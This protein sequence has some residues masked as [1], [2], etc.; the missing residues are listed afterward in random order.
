MKPNKF[1]NNK[2]IGIP[3]ALYQL[4]PAMYFNMLD[5]LSTKLQKLNMLEVGDNVVIQ[6]KTIIRNPNNIDLGD[7]VY[8]AREVE[9]TTE[10]NTSKLS[11][12]SGTRIAKK[13]YI[14]YTGNIEIGRSCTLSEN[15]MIQTHSHGLSPKNYAI[16]LSLKI[17]NNVWVGTRSVILHNVSVIGKNS[18][19]AAG[20]VVTKDVPENV[21]VAGNP[22]KVIKELN[23]K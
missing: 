17:N 3:G 10:I 13:T 5:K 11:I 22:A 16:P 2:I 9:M 20:S 23:V 12:G 1:W 18:I 21:I 7:Y 6:C 14:D 4:V 19:I 15:V 8:I